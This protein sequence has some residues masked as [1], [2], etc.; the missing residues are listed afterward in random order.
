[1]KK[2]SHRIASIHFK[3]KI[4]V[5]FFQKTSL[6]DTSMF[7]RPINR[8]WNPRKGL[9]ILVLLAFLRLDSNFEQ[10]LTQS[11]KIYHQICI[12]QRHLLYYSE[13]RWNSKERGISPLERA[14]RVMSVG[15]WPRW[16]ASYARGHRW[17]LDHV[18]AVLLTYRSFSIHVYSINDWR[19]S[20]LRES[21]EILIARTQS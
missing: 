19:N 9:V 15:V 6:R 1:M 10:D 7:Y 17:Q 8:Y 12:D 11:G 14:I 2:I 3:N 13:A 4:P 18:Y 16:W 5:P 20:D 21:W